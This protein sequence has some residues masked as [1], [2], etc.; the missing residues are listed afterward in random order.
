MAE[1]DSPTSAMTGHVVI[2]AVMAG[3]AL[4]FL[5][6]GRPPGRLAFIVVGVLIVAFV[7]ASLAMWRGSGWMGSVVFTILLVIVF[8]GKEGIA[9]I[10]VA[11]LL[12]ALSMMRAERR[13]LSEEEE[14]AHD[15]DTETEQ[16]T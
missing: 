4:V 8:Y 10:G 11:A 14:T 5:V 7:A 15:N 13:R 3:V 6:L 1:K 9:G 16:P 12:V 2:G